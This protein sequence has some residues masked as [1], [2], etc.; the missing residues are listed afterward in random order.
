MSVCKALTL[1]NEEPEV[2][3]YRVGSW[4]CPKTTR[5]ERLA[6]DKCYSLFQKSVN[7]G[8]KSFITLARLPN[9]ERDIFYWSDNIFFSDND[10]SCSTIAIS[11][12]QAL[13]D[14]VGI[15]AV[16]VDPACQA[17]CPIIEP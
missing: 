16:K 15:E 6:L 2:L 7:Y 11:S 17:Q 8:Q 4:P 3:H 1:P 13:V 10:S 5:L 9:H 14:E 12:C